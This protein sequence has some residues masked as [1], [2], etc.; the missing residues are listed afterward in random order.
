MGCI[1]LLEIYCDKLSVRLQVN[2]AKVL[3][4][5]ASV[6]N[7]HP[8]VFLPAEPFSLCGHSKFWRKIFEEIELIRQKPGARFPWEA[9]SEKKK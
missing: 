3:S 5:T 2:V 1:N 4:E 7:Q 6:Q 9:N 8:Q